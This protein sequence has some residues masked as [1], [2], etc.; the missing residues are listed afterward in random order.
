MLTATQTSACQVPPLIPGACSTLH[1][2][3]FGLPLL[4]RSRLWLPYLSRCRPPFP[5]ALAHFLPPLE[6]TLG[7]NP[8]KEH[9]H[10]AP[11]PVPTATCSLT[12][13]SGPTTTDHSPRE[14]AAWPVA[15]A[16]TLLNQSN[17]PRFTGQSL[18]F[19]V[20]GRRYSTPLHPLK[21][22]KKRKRSE[23]G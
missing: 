8:W 12:H 9:P 16:R 22:K 19:D 11:L 21:K 10:P 18:A 23:G 3:G 17:C 15:V 2:T 1:P 14:P 7:R 4:P 5:L 6:G 20:L 13:T